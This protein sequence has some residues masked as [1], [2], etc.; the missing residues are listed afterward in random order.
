MLVG[1]ASVPVKAQ[2]RDEANAPNVS[3]GPGISSSQAS[4]PAELTPTGPSLSGISGN[5]AAINIEAGNGMLGQALGF[6]SDSGVRV[7]GA[8]VGNASFLLTGGE[9]PAQSSFNS[10]LVA[11][12]NLDFGRL[13]NIPGGQ[14]GAQ[15]LQFNGQP[16][17]TEAGVV[18]GFN[19][20]TGPPPL[21]RSELYQL[22]WRQAL[23]DE[24]LV[25]R[26][27]KLVAPV[28]DFA[29]YL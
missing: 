1:L 9:K 24:K 14:F 19:G 3:P 20:L 21:V 6:G 28:I 4:A 16:T 13:A 18:T 2:Q 8:W 15:F 10:L 22:W 11:D 12:L 25:I 7:G 27:G 26:V 23:F 17:N 5:A 29:V